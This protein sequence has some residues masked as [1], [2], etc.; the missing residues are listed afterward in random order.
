M[1]L[2][3]L[4]EWFDHLAKAS[5]RE[6][7]IHCARP[8]VEQLGFDH[9]VYVMKVDL[10]P[11]RPS[12]LMLSG[13]PQDWVDRYSQEHYFDCDPVLA[14]AIHSPL[15]VLWDKDFQQAGAQEPGARQKQVLEE[16]AAHGLSHGITLAVR[17]DTGFNGVLTLARD[18]PLEQK[19]EDLIN[20]VGSVQILA[21]I[22]HAS[23]ERID[24]P[25]AVPEFHVHLTDRERQC[26][27]WSA[28][29]KTAWEVARILGISERT[30]IF[31]L[32]NS[33]TKLGAVNKTQA[34]TKA[35]SLGL[36]NLYQA[37]RSPALASSEPCT[38]VSGV[39]DL[40]AP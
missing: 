22:V 17:G 38:V 8:L 5:D 24:L 16:A 14:S 10:S 18:R 35:L 36:L 40:L 20:L 39:L 9:F 34:I 7:L 26:L 19:G 33:V 11:S 21:G 4:Y 27:Q 29:G 31:H 15:P 12:H 1:R 25:Q 3:S 37:D 32:N 13:Y 30:V 6:S 23:M 2:E 28:D